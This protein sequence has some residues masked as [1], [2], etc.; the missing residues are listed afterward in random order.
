MLRQINHQH[1]LIC[2]FLCLVELFELYTKRNWCFK[3]FVPPKIGRQTE[4]FKIKS[5]ALFKNHVQRE[6][7]RTFITSNSR[8]CLSCSNKVIW[9]SVVAVAI[10]VS[11]WTCFIRSFKAPIKYSVLVNN[12][13]II[14]ISL[15]YISS[16]IRKSGFGITF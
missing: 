8:Y 9:I 4:S 1:V 7:A 14:Y 11:L 10:V 12:S 16:A 13:V 15:L 2:W 5:V 6:I 3:N